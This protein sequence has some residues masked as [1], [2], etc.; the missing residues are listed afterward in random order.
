MASILYNLESKY[1]TTWKA[2]VIPFFVHISYYL[3]SKWL[4][5]PFSIGLSW[6]RKF[7][8]PNLGVAIAIDPFTMV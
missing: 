3:E 8:P 2:N 1:Y 6:P 7:L 4:A 5:T